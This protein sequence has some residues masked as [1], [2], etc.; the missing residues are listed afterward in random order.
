MQQE[1]LDRQNAPSDARHYSA[2]LCWVYRPIWIAQSKLC[3]RWTRL[4][5]NIDPSLKPVLLDLGSERKVDNSKAINELGW[6][7][8]DNQEAVLSCAK[9]VIEHGILN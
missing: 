2:K 3:C 6:Q 1:W 5:S 8:I 4:Y 9:S 7:P